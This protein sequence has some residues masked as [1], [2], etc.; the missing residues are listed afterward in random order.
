MNCP[1]CGSNNCNFVSNTYTKNGS[2]CDACCGF[3]LFG[4]IGILCGFCGYGSSTKE[5]WV[6]NNC[7][8]KFNHGG[9]SDRNIN[10]QGYGNKN[11]GNNTAIQRQSPNQPM[12]SEPHI[13]ILNTVY[14]KVPFSKTKN[15]NGEIL[16]EK[17]DLISTGNI[18]NNGFAATYK[19]NLYFVKSMKEDKKYI[20]RIIDGIRTNLYIDNA[21][22]LFADQ[23]GV[24]FLVYSK[25]KFI[26]D[27]YHIHFWPNNSNLSVAISQTHVKKMY[28]DNTH[29][30]YI[31][32]D[33]GDSIYRMN[34]NGSNVEKIFDGKCVNFVIYND[35]I[36]YIYKGENGKQIFSLS[37]DL[38]LMELTAKANNIKSFCIANDVIFYTR[39][40]VADIYKVFIYNIATRN[41]GLLIEFGISTVDMNVYEG[42][43]FLCNEGNVYKYSIRDNTFTVYNLGNISVNKINIIGDYIYYCDY[44]QV[45]GRVRINGTDN[46]RL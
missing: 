19:N 15:V 11:S 6:C 29:I 18:S 3:S 21:D 35:K 28:V 34:K 7:G 37:K 12:L 14:A 22:F 27:L 16:S 1:K 8:S 44:N 10:T 24:Y 31:N 36:Y 46:E 2:F 42:N 26:T 20:V 33:D 30:Y 32:A 45:L 23:D 13:A 40:N 38:M 4:P 25:S 41:E 43:I 9:Y 39:S 17:S 5:Y